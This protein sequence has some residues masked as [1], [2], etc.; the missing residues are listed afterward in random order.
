MAL[1]S[2]VKDDMSR[3]RMGKTLRNAG[4]SRASRV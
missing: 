3:R 1:W 4:A 2:P